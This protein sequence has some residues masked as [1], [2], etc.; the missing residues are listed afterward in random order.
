MKYQCQS[1]HVMEGSAL[2]R[3][4]SG[5]WTDPPVCLEPCTAFP[6]E[7]EQNNIQL[8]WTY[9]KKLYTPSGDFIEFACIR[10]YERDPESSD[11]RAHCVRG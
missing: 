2:V 3:C 6:E 4:L 11:F 5:H 9:D 10:G 8:R 1:F 7:M